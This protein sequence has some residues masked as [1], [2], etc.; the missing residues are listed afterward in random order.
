MRRSARSVRSLPTRVD[1][2][3][4]L[5]EKPTIIARAA[6]AAWPGYHCR[7]EPPCCRPAFVK[8]HHPTRLDVSAFARA[9]ATLEGTLPLAEL[10]RLAPST[11][12]P[13]DAGPG[14]ATWQARGLW[15]QPVGSE[16]Q[17]RLQL[18]ARARVWLTCQR[19]LQPVAH[20]L[21]AERTLRFVPTEEEAARLDD[22]EDDEDVLALP[23]TLNLHELVEDELILALPLV[24]RHEQCPEPLAYEPEAELPELEEQPDEAPHPFAAL[25]Q[26]KHK[27]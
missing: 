11:T 9:G 8:P 13:A 17:V 7:L 27:K 10:P 22:A 15:R 16:P 3:G 21:E 1:T 19:C 24:P 6:A 23:R 26:L 25:A 18:S 12:P 14:E 5:K 20:T 4:L 2:G